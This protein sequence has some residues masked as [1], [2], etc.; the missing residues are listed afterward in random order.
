MNN[1]NNTFSEQYAPQIRLRAIHLFME[2][3]T[4]N[5]AYEIATSEVLNAKYGNKY[6]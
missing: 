3:F 2:G 6:E 5:E 1:I 4:A